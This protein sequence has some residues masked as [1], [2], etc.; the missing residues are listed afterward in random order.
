MLFHVQMTVRIPPG[1]DAGKLAV[2][3]EREHERAKELQLKGKW[4]HL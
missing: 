3:N 1:T 4:P 2:L